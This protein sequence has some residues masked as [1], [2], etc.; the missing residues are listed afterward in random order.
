MAQFGSSGSRGSSFPSTLPRPCSLVISRE[1]LWLASCPHHLW[2]LTLRY[3]TDRTIHRLGISGFPSRLSSH[4]K[5]G[6]IRSQVACLS[7]S[8]T[9]MTRTFRCTGFIKRAHVHAVWGTRRPISALLVLTKYLEKEQRDREDLVWFSWLDSGL[10]RQTQLPISRRMGGTA[11]LTHPHPESRVYV[12]QLTGE[13]S[14][15]AN[16]YCVVH[17]FSLTNRRI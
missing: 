17:T 15:P 13:V 5:K 8:N 10:Q 14:T 7:Y 3:C 2:W 1:M 11:R 6:K 9:Q 4:I 16:H 12:A